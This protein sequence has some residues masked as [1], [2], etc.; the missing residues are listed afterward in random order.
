MAKNSF[1]HKHPD[2]AVSVAQK[3]LPNANVQDVTAVVNRLLAIG[4]IPKDGTI[5]KSA[6]DRNLNGFLKDAKDPASDT[7]Y[8]SIVVSQFWEKANATVG[9]VP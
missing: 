3:Y 5:S 6:W 8:E 1:V 4:A 7:P 2:Q 9:D